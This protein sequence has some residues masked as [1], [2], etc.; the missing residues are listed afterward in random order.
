M[1]VVNDDKADASCCLEGNHTSKLADLGTA[2]SRMPRPAATVCF[3]K[4]TNSLHEN[5]VLFNDYHLTQLAVSSSAANCLV[6]M[7]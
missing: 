4:F 3:T 2:S 5:G 1:P 7:L 6:F